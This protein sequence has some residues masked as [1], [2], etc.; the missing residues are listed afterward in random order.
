MSRADGSTSRAR[1]ALADTDR[2]LGPLPPVADLPIDDVLDAIRRD[3][4][5]VDGTPALRARRPDSAAHD[6][7][8]D[9]TRTGIAGQRCGSGSGVGSASGVGALSSSL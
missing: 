6:V 8:N 3:K 2:A 4:K 5:V 9:V 1:T 7:V